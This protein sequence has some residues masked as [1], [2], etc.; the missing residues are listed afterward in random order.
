VLDIDLF[1]QNRV[2]AWSNVAA[3]INYAA[4]FAVAFLLSLYLQYVKGLSPQGA[5]FVLVASPVVQ[6]IF[7][8]SAGRL[9]DR[10]EPRI[11]ASTGMGLTALGLLLLV[12]VTEQ[13]GLGFIVGSLALI[14]FGFAL[15]SSPNTNAVM[16]SVEKKCYGVASAILATMRQTGMM[17][18]MGL[19]MLIFAVYLG[20]VQITPEYHAAFLKSMH[21]AFIV[22]TVLCLGGIFAS[23]TRGKVR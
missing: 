18:S 8:P 9:S 22:C 17:L 13:T 6:A 3:L 2:F 7:S 12:F 10:I 5:G 20:R 16:G 4:T 23:L 21:T 1:R 14:G 19:V 15:F 11:V